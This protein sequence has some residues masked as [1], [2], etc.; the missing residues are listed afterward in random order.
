MHPLSMQPQLLAFSTAW[1]WRW[2]K[3]TNS[4]FFI[5]FNK[6]ANASISVPMRSQCRVLS[7]IKLAYWSDV[8]SF[9]GSCTKK[10]GTPFYTPGLTKI[11]LF[12]TFLLEN[13]SSWAQR[14]SSCVIW[15]LQCY[16]RATTS[17]PISLVRCDVIQGISD[18]GWAPSLLC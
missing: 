5:F 17:H 11:S 2:H 18:R 14:F 16:A 10:G 13:Q 1:E 7:P 15:P 3:A 4:G 6:L 9:Q 12:L 8:S